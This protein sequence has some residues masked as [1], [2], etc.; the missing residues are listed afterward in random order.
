MDVP[1]VFRTQ[2]RSAFTRIEA[3]C[4]LLARFRS[5]GDQFD[6]S[7]QYNRSQSAISEVVNELTE[8]LDDTWSHLLDFD[9][10]GLLTR[11]RMQI[12]ADAIHAAGAPLRHI[13][14]F[15]DCTIR[16]MCRPSW[17]Q[18]Q[19][20]NGHKKV[21]ANKFQAVKTPDGM[22]AHLF[23]PIEGRRNDNHLLAESKILEKCAQFALRPGADQNT[24]IQQRYFQ[25][26]GDPAYGVS[27]LLLSP[28]SADQRTE[29][30]TAWN[31]AM[32]AV[33]IEVEHG[34]GDITRQWPFLNAWWKHRVYSSPIGRYYRVAVLLANALNC[35]R[36]NQTSTYFDCEP[37]L[38]EDY[39]HAAE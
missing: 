34:F 11:T 15:I 24:P 20:Y 28:F 26:F 8:Y 27:P 16:C 9:T 19:V 6:L 23:G 25:L 12:Y 10:N 38:L 32:A 14:G 36:P 7:M 29:E 3:L 22:I 30:Q 13:W 2:N 4:L 17:W 39:F 35:L 18:R 1:E 33:R 21:H 37:P 31:A 5:A